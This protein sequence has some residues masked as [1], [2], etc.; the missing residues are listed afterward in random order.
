MSTQ[1][2][3]LHLLSQESFEENIEGLKDGLTSELKTVS[4]ILAT[5]AAG[6]GEVSVENF[7]EIK[8]LVRLGLHRKIPVEDSFVAERETALTIDIGDSTGITA[9]TIDEET[10]VAAVGT[11]HNGV[12][13]AVY[14]GAVWHKEDNEAISL[15]AYGITVTGTPAEGDKVVITE[16]ASKIILDV[17]DHDVNCAS[18]EQS[19][20]FI[21]RDVIAYGTIP[22]SAPQLMIYALAEL[23]AG[24]YKFTLNHA[25]NGGGVIQNGTYMFTT[26][27]AIPAGGGIRHSKVGEWSQSAHTKAEITA[28]KV[29]TYGVQ[30]NRTVIESNLAVSE[31]DGETVCTDLGTVAARDKQYIVEVENLTKVNFS[32]R[33]IYGSNRYAHS[34]YR[35][36]LNSTGKAVKSG[37]TTFSYWWTPSDVFDMPPSAAARQMAGFLH[38]LDPDLVDNI[39]EATIVV[40]IPSPDRVS[41]GD[42]T[43]TL[44]DKVFL[45]SKTEVYGG[46]NISG[47]E[48][49][50]LEIFSGTS[51]SDKIK[52]QNGTARC[53]WL[54][55]ALPSNASNV[56][57][58]NTSG[59]LVNSYADITYGVVCGLLIKSRKSAE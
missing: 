40:E 34:C 36:W 20:M 28:G 44:N 6:T 1:S 42:T 51:N 31:W 25:D 17:A 7:K 46:N 27:Q 47:K 57:L 58:V 2:N 3:P 8:N 19:I 39:G 50:L 55:S 12:Y 48:G 33:Q 5:I 16:T 43:E 9:A 29:T 13:E 15:A 11:A 18:N 41:G 56:R 32:E 24:N 14:D 53:W 30:P 10:F 21:S 4:S 22:F 23:P 49:E 59:E 54:R 52:Y 38:G 37:D 26:T 45:M 35:K